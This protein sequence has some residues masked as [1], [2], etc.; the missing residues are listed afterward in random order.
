LSLAK[1]L[2]G[3]NPNSKLRYFGKL[4][5]KETVYKHAY[6][7]P[8]TPF[9]GKAQ[10]QIFPRLENLKKN[11]F[12]KKLDFQ[13][14]R[15]IKSVHNLSAVQNAPPGHCLPM[16]E[17]GTDTLT[18]LQVRLTH[19]FKTFASPTHNPNLS[20]NASPG[21]SPHLVLLQPAI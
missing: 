14:K 9:A 17:L 15:K 3:Q 7:H 12:F 21:V 4:E 13:S 2:N 16:Q 6:T 11:M 5:L 19:C 8:R 18:H 1:N 20:P 10:L